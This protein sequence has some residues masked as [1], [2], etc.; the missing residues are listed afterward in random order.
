LPRWSGSARPRIGAIVAF[1]L[2]F[3]VLQSLWGFARGSRIEHL[4]IDQATAGVAA[5]LI[6]WL[7]PGVNAVAEGSRVNAAGGGINILNGCEGTE[8]LFLLLPALWVAP[9]GWRRRLIGCLLGT[10]WVFALNQVRVVT[11]FYA[12]RSDMGLFDLLHG[13]VAP[14]VLIV[15]VTAF[16]AAIVRLDPQTAR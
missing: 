12:H 4:V 2:L 14:L 16:F 9:L 1:L 10:V 13:V 3:F 11:L 6:N 7:T 15:L 8:V 5:Q